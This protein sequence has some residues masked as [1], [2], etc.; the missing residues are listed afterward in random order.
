MKRISVILGFALVLFVIG[1]TGCAKD[2]NMVSGTVKYKELLTGDEKPADGATV[3]LM[4]SDDEYAM[5]T[6]AD[7]DGKYSFYPVPDGDYWVE[8]DYDGLLITYSGKSEKFSVKGKQQ[9]QM[10]LTLSAISN[11][12]A[13]KV[14][15]EQNGQEYVLSQTTVYLYNAG[16]D[17]PIDSVTT[18]DVG[19]FI[20]YGLNDGSYDIDAYY[21]ENDTLYYDAVTNISVSGGKLVTADLHLTAQ[22]KKKN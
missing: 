10:D 20:F 22:S 9:V 7:K 16:G 1:L 4:V 21:E 13:G 5:K 14:Y 8:A 18:D 19:Y 2:Q 11:S 15:L 17:N 3:Y 6:V 12:I